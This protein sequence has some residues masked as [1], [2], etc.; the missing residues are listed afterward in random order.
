MS[1]SVLLFLLVSAG[2]KG[3]QNIKRSLRSDVLSHLKSYD[4]RETD[5]NKDICA[6]SVLRLNV[7][8]LEQTYVQANPTLAQ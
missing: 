6:F 4:A 1:G 2:L 8:I 7:Y 5:E 3:F